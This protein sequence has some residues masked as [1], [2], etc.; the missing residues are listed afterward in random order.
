MK[1]VWQGGDRHSKKQGLSSRRQRLVLVSSIDCLLQ[2]LM[3]GEATVLVALWANLGLPTQNIFAVDRATDVEPLSVFS[4]EVPG[5]RG[6]LL[7]HLNLCW[8]SGKER[9]GRA[10]F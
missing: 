10:S 3:G 7:E 5:E 1:E 8:V 6:A 2:G 4:D 9:K